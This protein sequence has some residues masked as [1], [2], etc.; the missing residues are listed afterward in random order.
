MRH[1][2]ATVLAWEKEKTT[3]RHLE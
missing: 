2:R 3:I 1:E